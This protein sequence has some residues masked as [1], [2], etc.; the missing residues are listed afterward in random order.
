MFQLYSK[1]AESLQSGYAQERNIPF[2]EE[3][4]NQTL[5]AKFLPLL[6]KIRM[7]SEVENTTEKIF[8]I[9]R[10]LLIK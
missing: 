4:T 10:I 8:L 3:K 2:Q 5:F 9:L 7:K 6:Q 1:L